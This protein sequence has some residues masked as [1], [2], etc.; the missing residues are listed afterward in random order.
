MVQTGLLL[1]GV[2]ETSDRPR[3]LREGSAKFW[4]EACSY[5]VMVYL[6][7]RAWL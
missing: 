4:E 6:M 2:T 1:Q 3:G 7:Y 5:E